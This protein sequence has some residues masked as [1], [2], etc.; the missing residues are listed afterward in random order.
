M[1]NIK[2]SL[3]SSGGGKALRRR[4]RKPG[5]FSISGC[6]AG[7]NA[8][9]QE[10]S[11]T[12]VRLHWDTCPSSHLSSPGALLPMPSSAP[13]PFSALT[14]V[15]RRDAGQIPASCRCT[16]ERRGSGTFPEIHRA[17]RAEQDPAWA[18]SSNSPS[19]AFC[20]AVLFQPGCARQQAAPTCLSPMEKT[21]VS[22]PRGS[23]GGGAGGPHPLSCPLHRGLRQG[24]GTPGACGH[25]AVLDPVP[26][27][28]CT[29]HK[30]E[31]VSACFPS[32]CQ[33]HVAGSSWSPCMTDPCPQLSQD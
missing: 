29:S 4:A 27:S 17:W 11:V 5:Y 28:L 16:V 24:A 22:Q 7:G 10:N 1:S 9:P 12:A 32:G 25:G 21:E 3:L 23:P 13:L 31:S 8:H 15:A 20:C 30:Q 26:V 33:C 14:G 18:A 19:P 6:A 2:S